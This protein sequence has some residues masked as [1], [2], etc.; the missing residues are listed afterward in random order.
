[1]SGR[2]GGQLLRGGVPGAG[3]AAGWQQ[4]AR[5]MYAP[6]MFNAGRHG[7]ACALP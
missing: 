2:E 5:A 4:V 7:A 3:L 1:M 6:H